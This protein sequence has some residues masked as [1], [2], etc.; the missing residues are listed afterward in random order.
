M[1][2][3][4]K[5]FK[6]KKNWKSILLIGL[7]CI[8]LVGAVVGICSM[9]REKE[10]ETTKVVN[11]TYAV[12][13][14]TEDGRFLETEKS[15][16]TKDAFDCL[17]LNIDLAFKNDIS[18]RIF[19]YDEEEDFVSSTDKLIADFEEEIPFDATQCRIVI[20]PND[21][22]KISWYEKSGYAEQLTIKVAIE[23]EKEIINYFAVDDSLVGK[24]VQPKDNVVGGDVV[25]TNDDKATY[26]TSA[27]VDVKGWKKLEIQSSLGMLNGNFIF[28]DANGKVI[29]CQSQVADLVNEDG[30]AI[31]TLNVP[32]NATQFAMCYKSG[33]YSNGIYRVA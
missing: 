19:F 10:E 31:M 17:G 12:G 24:F 33:N 13:G 2:K 5:L 18:Y 23:Q 9:F 26:N 28:I 20:T 8:M 30:V 29:S 16:Y 11:P 7:S 15:I 27:F 14:L 4:K 1:A 25:Y 21:N 22:T 3:I 32:E 6:S